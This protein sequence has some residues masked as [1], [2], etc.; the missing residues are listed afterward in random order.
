MHHLLSRSNTT[1]PNMMVTPIRFL[2]VYKGAIDGM[3]DRL[4][5]KP[6]SFGAL[7]QLAGST[8]SCLLAQ[9]LVM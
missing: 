7:G 3:S 9:D 1:I 6:G 4:A 2:S 5:S 8:Y